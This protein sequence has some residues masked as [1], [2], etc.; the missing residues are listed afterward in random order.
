MQDEQVVEI[1]I[2]DVH[3]REEGD[4]AWSTH[5]VGEG[6]EVQ[7]RKVKNS[8]TQSYHKLAQSV[9][10]HAEIL[11]S[12]QLLDYH[13]NSCSE[14]TQDR[15][16]EDDDLCGGFFQSSACHCHKAHENSC[17]KWEN[18]TLQTCLT[19]RIKAWVNLFFL[20]LIVLLE[21]NENYCSETEA[22]CNNLCKNYALTKCHK[23][24]NG[25]PERTSLL[26]NH[27]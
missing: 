9:L 23:C 15:I 8:R 1:G 2:H 24:Y 12:D 7:G 16:V 11:I 17:Q 10:F 3:V 26:A 4:K 18:D 27:N 21:C 25:Y 6:G 5:L 20:L 22:H 19:L 13:V 14:Y